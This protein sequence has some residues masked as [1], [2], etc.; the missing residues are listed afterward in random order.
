MKTN[1]MQ[2][3]CK[4]EFFKDDIVDLTPVEAVEVYFFFPDKESYH[5][6]HTYNVMHTHHTEASSTA[7][8]DTHHHVI[9]N[10]N[11]GDLLIE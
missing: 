3:A 9:M 7:E 11:T 1:Y 10:T 4:D 5:M 6:M 8:E 2:L